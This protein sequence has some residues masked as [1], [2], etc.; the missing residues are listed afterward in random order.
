MAGEQPL[1][2]S[3]H[4]IMEHED[5]GLPKMPYVSPGSSSTATSHVATY[6][7]R[8]S[9]TFSPII[10]SNLTL[11]NYLVSPDV[12][13]IFCRLSVAGTRVLFFG[14]LIQVPIIAD[15]DFMVMVHAHV[16]SYFMTNTLPLP[17]I[18]NLGTKS[19]LFDI[20]ILHHFPNKYAPLAILSPYM[21]YHMLLSY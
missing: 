2:P 20:N 19:L 7:M 17:A 4:L 3:K 18:E 10:S 5:I 8:G 12:F 21:R 15:F 14:S 6:S 9:S 13:I 16:P 1:R 11:G